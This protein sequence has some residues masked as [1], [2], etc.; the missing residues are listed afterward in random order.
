MALSLLL[1]P[2]ST[3]IGALSLSLRDLSHSKRSVQVVYK[4]KARKHSC[5][6]G[7]KAFGNYINRVGDAFCQ[8][9]T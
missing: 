3:L 9:L 5:S 7:N 6:G 8:L 2:C 4:I 1:R